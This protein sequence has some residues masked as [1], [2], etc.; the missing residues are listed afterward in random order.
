MMEEWGPVI[1]DGIIKERLGDK[2]KFE[3]RPGRSEGISLW[4]T[5]WKRQKGSNKGPDGAKN[6]ACSGNIMRANVA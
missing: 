6:L 4:I 1:L 2:C 5:W 3:Q